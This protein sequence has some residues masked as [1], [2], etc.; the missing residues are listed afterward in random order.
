MIS[1][2]IPTQFV[3]IYY[4]SLVLASFFITFFGIMLFRGSLPKDQGREFAVNGKLSEG[5]P[6]GAGII[7]I[8][9]FILSSVLFVPLNSE[10]I[11]YLALIFI[12]MISGY[13][14][15]GSK[16]P[17][18]EYKKGLIDLIVAV[19]VSVT[20]YSFNGSVINFALLGIRNV[21]IPA[22]IFIILGVILVWAAINVTNCSDGV[23]GLCGSLTTIS[24][25][26]AYVMLFFLGRGQSFRPMLLI[27]IITVLAYLWYNAS[28]SKLLMGDA[29]SRALGV[30]L[31]IAFLQTGSPFTFIFAAFIL[32]IDGGL[33]LIK[34]SVLRFLKV[35][36]FMK[37]IR[38]PIHD[39]MRKIKD[40]SDTQVVFRFSIMQIIISLV[41]IS[42]ALKI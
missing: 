25:M 37:N 7:L 30:I 20:Y 23:D 41:V 12:E 11:I 22:V 3:N 4:V 19:G 38:T 29:G 40:W 10:L 14:D 2:L 5:K 17:W 35:N 16:V 36:G 1:N 33:G 21:K 27:I 34:V 28:P 42:F 13:L 9:T 6:R 31:A 39:H 26:T 15:D 8:I 24:L 18:G 32:I